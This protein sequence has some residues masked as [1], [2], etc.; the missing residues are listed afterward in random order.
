M[1]VSS[2]EAAWTMSRQGNR[3][4]RRR[5]N[6]QGN[7]NQ[8]KFVTTWRPASTFGMPRSMSLDY[9][10]HRSKSREATPMPYSKLYR[11]ESNP[12]LYRSVKNAMQ[13]VMNK[14]FIK[15]LDLVLQD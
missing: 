2:R 1:I 9:R 3:T 8:E 15:G 5:D 4:A 6:N 13:R 12:H 7:N 10:R 14:M 11:Y